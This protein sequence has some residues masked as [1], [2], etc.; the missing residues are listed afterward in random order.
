MIESSKSMNAKLRGGF[1]SDVESKAE[2]GPE[3]MLPS[4]MSRWAMRYSWKYASPWLL[5][6]PYDHEI[7]YV[8]YTPRGLDA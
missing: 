4:E 1:G 3:R 7:R 5:A 8:C 2:R 6:E